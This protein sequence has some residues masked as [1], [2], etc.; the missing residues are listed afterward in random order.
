[1]HTTVRHTAPPGWLGSQCQL[2]GSLGSW[3]LAQD[4]AVTL[5]GIYRPDLGPCS[6][7]DATVRSSDSHNSPEVETTGTSVSRQTSRIWCPHGG[8]V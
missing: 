5:Q 4:P 1:M 2:T 8:Y 3:D 7:L 6:S